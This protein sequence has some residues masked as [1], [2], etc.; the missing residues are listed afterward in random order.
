MVKRRILPASRRSTFRASG[1]VSALVL[2]LLYTMIVPMASTVA[3]EDNWTGSPSIV[4]SVK[5]DDD[6]PMYHSGFCRVSSFCFDEA[7]GVFYVADLFHHSIIRLSG[8]GARSRIVLP[9]HMSLGSIE[10]YAGQIYVLDNVQDLS[11]PARLHVLSTD[12][13]VVAS[14]EIPLHD[15]Y[16]HPVSGEK[17][18]RKMQTVYAT[19]DGV[20][21]SDGR[22]FLLQS[23]QF[24]QGA[25]ISV[26]PD[27]SA[28]EGLQLRCNIVQYEDSRFVAPTYFGLVQPL[29][30]KILDDKRLCLS[31]WDVKE[32]GL[33]RK[34]AAIT[35]FTGEMMVH[36]IP[37]GSSFLNDPIRFDSSGQLY[38]ASLDGNDLTISKVSEFSTTERE[39]LAHQT[40][41]YWGGTVSSEEANAGESEL[42]EQEAPSTPATEANEEDTS[43]YR[44]TN[45]TFLYF[46]IGI[47]IVA[48][49]WVIRRRI[50]GER[51]NS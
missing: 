28:R 46:C 40:T 18:Y 24:V 9:T 30:L 33:Y 39:V 25:Q 15:D 32:P 51:S 37:L 26:I 41:P 38:V 31:F 44:D 11:E 36:Y 20:V 27:E 35:S 21:I 14:Y 23:G 1:F 42:T 17:L 2:A 49:V 12:G 43:D 10:F 47:G 3:E 6:L 34:V 7:S 8:D 4:A 5:F 29:V 16:S 50:A 13:N 19:D 45:S 22:E 48:I